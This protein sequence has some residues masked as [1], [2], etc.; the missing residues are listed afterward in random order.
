MILGLFVVGGACYWRPHRIAA[1]E[2]G[3]KAFVRLR[4]SVSAVA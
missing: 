3:I 1:S 2:A 4:M